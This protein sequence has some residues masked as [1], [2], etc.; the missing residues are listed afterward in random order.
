M[1]ENILDHENITF[2]LNV[3][4]EKKMEHNFKHTFFMFA[5]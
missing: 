3:N 5:H 2:D 4:F 1:F